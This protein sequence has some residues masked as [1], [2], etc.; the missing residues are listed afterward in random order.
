[1]RQTDS[2]ESRS[3]RGLRRSSLAAVAVV[4]WFAATSSPRALA[5]PGA[6]GRA[7]AG[8]RCAR[9]EA[10]SCRARTPR[11]AA[12]RVRRRRRG[13]PVD[14]RRWSPPSSSRAAP[15]RAL[16]P[17]PKPP[18]VA[19]TPCS[20]SP[21][22]PLADVPARRVAPPTG[23]DGH[24]IVDGLAPGRYRLRVTGTGLLAAEVRF[25]P[26]PSDEARIVVARQVAIEGTVTDGGKPVAERDGRHPR[27]RDRRRARG[28]RPTRSGAFDVPNL[29]EGRYQVY[30]WQGALAARAVRVNRLGAGPFAPRRAPARGRR[31]R[32]RP[33][34]RSRRGHRARRGDRAAAD[35]ATIR[36]RATRA[37][38]TTACSASRA[39]RTARWIAD[40]FAPGY[41]SPGGVELEAG[42]G[43]PELALARGAA[44]EGR[45]VDGEG[46]PVAGATVR[47]L[48]RGHEPDRVLRAG[49]SGSAAPV[50]RPHGGADRDPRSRS[51]A[52]RSS[53]RAA[54]SA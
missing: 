44:I 32:R 52:I 48:T 37:A 31:D 27:R 26:V 50:L 3:A 6:C 9:R 21:S 13:L 22:R 4:L 11:R 14:G 1:M 33:R 45:V 54:S 5:G 24:F 30:A 12:H 25:V 42:K 49:R 43:V 15:D 7:A 17:A 51:A 16:A 47:A 35:R 39:C 38:A 36:R 40:A 46:H 23:A 41:L 18:A 28:R 8:P 10:R 53:S 29:P 2:G 20:R 19:M 34:D